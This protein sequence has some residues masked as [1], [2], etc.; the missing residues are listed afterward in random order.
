MS[1]DTK[2]IIY[3]KDEQYYSDLYDCQTVDVC[4][5]HEKSFL[6]GEVP[7]VP[8]NL[9]EK[10]ARKLLAHMALYNLT[11][12]RFAEKSTTID[13]W[14]RRDRAK[15]ERVDKAKAPV[16]IACLY[17]LTPMICTMK[18]LHGHNDDHVLFF[19]NCPSC[20][21]N[22]A[23]YETGEEYRPAQHKCSKCGYSVD[24]TDVRKGNQITSTYNC[25][26]CGFI[27]TDI[28]DLDEDVKEKPDEDFAKDRERFCLSQKDGLDYIGY[29]VKMDSMKMLLAKYAEKDKEKD[30]YDAVAKIKKLGIV[31]LEKLLGAALS[32][33]GFVKLDFS[34]PE[35]TRFI[36]VGFTVQ[37]AKSVTGNTHEYDRR[38]ALKKAIEKALYD[39]N[40]QL[41]SDSI[42]YR[43]GI[44]SGRIKGLET[45]N[46]IVEMVKARIHKEEKKAG[47]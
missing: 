20:N 24:S 29:R 25:K 32:D 3:L 14:M 13:N 9:D 6:E 17:C 5:R 41:I 8:P 27:E 1:G 19:F 45:E 2:T 38:L 33:V 42:V 7:E 40:W 47:K 11:G 30:V 18:D 12:E 43:L 4:R 46:E 44:L 10:N 28:L 34:K 26:A 37:D 22:R 21:K 31:D 16:G 23:F 35:M 36:V 39:T 15:D